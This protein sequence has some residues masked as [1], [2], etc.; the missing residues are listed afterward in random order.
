[1]WWLKNRRMV[2]LLA[3]MAFWVLVLG[4]IISVLAL[5]AAGVIS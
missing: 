1:M 4:G 2:W 5:N 3:R